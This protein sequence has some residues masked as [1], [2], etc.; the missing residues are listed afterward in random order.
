MTANFTHN[1]Q[2]R[3]TIVIALCQVKKCGCPLIYHLE[4]RNG[5]QVLADDPVSVFKRYAL[6]YAK[7]YF[8]FCLRDGTRRHTKI[9]S[10]FLNWFTQPKHL[11]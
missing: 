10:A 11:I 8:F 3:R 1:A 5:V 7:V 6:N 2:H 4:L 9:F